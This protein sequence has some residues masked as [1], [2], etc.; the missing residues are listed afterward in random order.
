MTEEAQSQHTYEVGNSVDTDL[1][2]LSKE[3]EEF[4]L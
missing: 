1:D 2:D 3:L 4:I